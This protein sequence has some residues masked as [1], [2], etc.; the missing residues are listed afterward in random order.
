MKKIEKTNFGGNFMKKN[1]LKVN[2]I[3]QKFVSDKDKNL[4][5][6]MSECIL[7]LYEA[8]QKLLSNQQ[9]MFET[10]KVL[11]TKLMKYEP[12]DASIQKRFNEYAGRGKKDD[13]I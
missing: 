2:E 4:I 5:N 1:Q 13:A 7:K 6:S 11:I 9:S 3:I 8:N 12:I 10:N